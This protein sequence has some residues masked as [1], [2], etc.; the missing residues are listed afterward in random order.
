MEPI[1]VKAYGLINF[2]K[3]QYVITQLIVFA[4][5]ITLFIMSF[6]YDFDRFLFG[7]AKIFILVIAFLECI[8]TYVMLKK[9]KE[10]NNN[11]V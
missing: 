7:Y 10:K 6:F 2:T 9:F 5:L 4:I 11:K 8:E 3:K 1:K